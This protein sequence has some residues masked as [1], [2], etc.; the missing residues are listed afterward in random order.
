MTSAPVISAPC[1]PV[2]GV[3]RP[4]SFAFRGIPYAQAPVGDL[5]F[6]APV[7]REPWTEPFDASHFGATPQR[8]SP[9]AVATIPE[10]CIPGEDTLNL[11]VYTP[12]LATHAGLPVHVY[13]HGGG[14]IGGS[15]AGEWF[16]GATYNRDGVVVVTISYRLGFEGFGWIADAPRNRGLLD[17]VC[18]LEWVRDNIRAFGGD[19]AKVTISG[20]S[21]GGGAVLTLLSMPAASGL[22]RGVIAQSPVLG[23]AAAAEHEARGRAFAQRVG[24]QPTV[25]GWSAL[26]ELAVLELQLAEM[27]AVQAPHPSVHNLPSAATAVHDVAMPWGPA[28]DPESLP[29][30]PRVAWHNG[31]N[32][33]VRVVV[34]A[35]RDEF[36]IPDAA[37]TADVAAA[38]L[39]DVALP[40]PLVEFGRQR[41]AAGDPDPLGRLA[42][43]VYFRL[44]VLDT[45]DMRSLAGG[46]TWIYDFAEPSALTGLAAH[47]LDLPYTWDCL[48]AP[49]ATKVLGAQP[50]QELADAMHGAWVAF[51]RDGDPGW[52]AYAADGGGKVFGGS[53][54]AFADVRALHR[55]FTHAR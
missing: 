47:C 38:W 23:L 7:R 18:A 37:P 12:T 36:V 55:S 4:G 13:I 3:A 14:Y 51:I 10:P 42:T 22:F 21:A 25:A 43:A 46:R 9:F 35:T 33:D 52:P 28:L 26:P 19:P 45:A 29:V 49:S 15:H 34:G 48:A 1:G 41:L 17:M 2:V 39:A 50:S 24:V 53:G 5:R 31:L 6:A 20:Q 40:K 16:D 27:A 11:N 30:A 44:N 32:R 8:R 54:E